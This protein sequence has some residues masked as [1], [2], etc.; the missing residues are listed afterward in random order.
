[1]KNSYVSLKHLY[2]CEIYL[3]CGTVPYFP[4]GSHIP[5]RFKQRY[6]DEMGVEYSS[7]LRRYVAD[8]SRVWK[9]Y[10]DNYADVLEKEH[11]R[12]YDQ[13]VDIVLG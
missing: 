8:Y 12:S 5:N 2:L 10:E 1:M 11:I 4:S 13:L 6:F 7:K 3:M 9:Y